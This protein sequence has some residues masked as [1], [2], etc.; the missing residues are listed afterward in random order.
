MTGW[1]KLESTIPALYNDIKTN[2]GRT[3]ADLFIMSAGDPGNPNSLI[4]LSIRR[5]ALS[6]PEP[7]TISLFTKYQPSAL[8]PEYLDIGV[9]TQNVWMFF[10]MRK[11][12]NNLKVRINTSHDGLQRLDY[13]YEITVPTSGNAYSTID[14][15]QV[16]AVTD[17]LRYYKEVLT[18]EEI[19]SLINPAQYT[20]F[21]PA[22]NTLI[23]GSGK[24]YE[25]GATY[26]PNNAALKIQDKNKWPQ[27]ATPQYVQAWWPRPIEQSVYDQLKAKWIGY[28]DDVSTL[29]NRL[30][31]GT[32]SMRT[33]FNLDGYVLESVNI[34]MLASADDYIHN[35]LINGKPTNLNNVNASIGIPVTGSQYSLPRFNNIWKFELPSGVSNL[36][37]QGNNTLEFLVTAA[38]SSSEKQNPFGIIV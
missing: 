31:P 6:T 8:N 38:K 5:S 14:T 30:T 3:T 23:Q 29:S 12:G 24:P 7:I 20:D 37:V 28:S 15:L 32:Y 33:T 10:C 16:C 34:E 21:V 27:A 35:I 11:D 2:V 17:D 13:K 22:P 19:E 26:V 4:K 36:Y 1:V 25:Y 18:D 9:S